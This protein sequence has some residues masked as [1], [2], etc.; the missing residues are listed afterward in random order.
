MLDALFE[1]PSQEKKGCF[2][3]TKEIVEGTAP[4][5]VPPTDDK[6]KKPAKKVAAK[7]RRKKRREAS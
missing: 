2:T 1:L 3:L 4:S 7:P 5:F 6:P